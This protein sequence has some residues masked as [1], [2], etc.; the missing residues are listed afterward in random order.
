MLVTNCFH[1]AC[2]YI[3]VGGEGITHYYL[4]ER[5]IYDPGECRVWDDTIEIGVKDE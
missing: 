5:N 1:S 3:R 4:C 2:P